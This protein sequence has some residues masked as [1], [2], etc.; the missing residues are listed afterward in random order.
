ML[1]ENHLSVLVLLLVLVNLFLAQEL[2]LFRDDLCDICHLLT[3]VFL[4]NLLIH[5]LF[6]NEK[7][8]LG[9]FWWGR[10]YF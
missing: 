1:L 3:R 10:L 8:A 9:S 4:L 6:E 2:I 5:F 7:C